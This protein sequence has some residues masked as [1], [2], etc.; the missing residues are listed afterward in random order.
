ML[1][2]KHFSLVYDLQN[3]ALHVEHPGLDPD[4]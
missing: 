3:V 4:R 1:P 2:S